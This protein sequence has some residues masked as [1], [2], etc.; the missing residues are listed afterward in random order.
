MQSS[1]ILEEEREL[2]VWSATG[3][4]CFSG[5]E[6]EM[7]GWFVGFLRRVVEVDWDGDRYSGRRGEMERL[8]NLK[9]VFGEAFEIVWREVGMR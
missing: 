2:L 6:G 4:A 3:G 5:E 8:L 1:V 7:R 9:G